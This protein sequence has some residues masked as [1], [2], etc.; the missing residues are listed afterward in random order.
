MVVLVAYQIVALASVLYVSCTLKKYKWL[1]TPYLLVNTKHDG[2]GG[3]R[4]SRKGLVIHASFQL[5]LSLYGYGP[6]LAAVL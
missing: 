6:L 5:F 2:E 3:G 1:G 4:T